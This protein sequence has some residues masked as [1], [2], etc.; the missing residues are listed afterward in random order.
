MEWKVEIM[1]DGRLQPFKEKVRELQGTIRQL[2]S[3]IE[4]QQSANDHL[5]KENEHLRQNYDMLIYQRRKD[6]LSTMTRERDYI[7]RL[8]S[9]EMTT[10]L[11]NLWRFQVL[12][13]RRGWVLEALLSLRS[14]F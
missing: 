10:K 3:T 14:L 2:Q 1:I 8:S 12:R 4:Q 7:G 9:V 11:L 13:N 6:V 5:T